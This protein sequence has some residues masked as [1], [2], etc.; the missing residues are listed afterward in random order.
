MQVVGNL[1]IF[2]AFG[3]LAPLRFAALARLAVLA[4][5]AAARP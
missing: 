3:F 2:A 5:A 1:L 4:L